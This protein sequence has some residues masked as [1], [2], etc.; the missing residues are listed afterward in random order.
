MPRRS[1]LI[2]ISAVSLAVLAACAPPP[3]VPAGPPPAAPPG[4]QRPSAAGHPGFDTGLYPGDAAMRAWRAASPYEWVGY[5]LPAPCHRDVSWA[6]KR[7]A[8]IDMGWAVAAIY[9]G[10]QDWG[11][12][13]DRQIPNPQPVTGDSTAVAQSP[14]AANQQPQQPQAQARATGACSAANLG[15]GY[16]DADD[17]IARAAAEG[18]PTGSVIYLDVERVQAVSASLVQ[19]VRDWV[20][21]VLQEGRYIPGL[22]CHRANVADLSGALTSPWIGAGRADTPPLWVTATDP[23]FTL[24][25]QPRGSGVPTATV[26]QG[27]LD[28]S[29]SWGG[30]TLRVDQNVSSTRGPSSPP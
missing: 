30:T 18:F 17:A 1:V 25:Q 14:P 4:P 2:S 29:E 28:V 16:S 10:Q 20:G 8:L 7:S 11:Q 6:G 22:Y 9:V 15:R 3:S 5:Y 23:S 12:M 24:D 21:R 27:R 26:W 19:Y 13:P